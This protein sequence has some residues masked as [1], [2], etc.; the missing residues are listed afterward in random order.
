VKK[1]LAAHAAIHD[2]MPSS[3]PGQAYRAARANLVALRTEGY[4]YWK[5]M[6]DLLDGEYGTA[7]GS[8]TAKNGLGYDRRL[9]GAGANRRKRVTD[10]QPVTTAGKPAK[11]WPPVGDPLT[12]GASAPAEAPPMPLGCVLRSGGPSG[13]VEPSTLLL[14]EPPD[15]SGV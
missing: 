8:F 1:Q 6:H 13:E 15:E 3:T 14:R 4:D 11:A 2:A 5:R 12:G 7:P 10:P 9:R